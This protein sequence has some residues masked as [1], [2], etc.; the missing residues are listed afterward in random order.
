MEGDVGV[1]QGLAQ[2]WAE[3]LPD[4]QTDG[5]NFRSRGAG[6][7]CLP[8][9]TRPLVCLQEAALKPH[10]QARCSS[11]LCL[12]KDAGAPG[13]VFLKRDGEEPPYVG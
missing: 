2:S 12:F 6:L 13:R 9:K 4:P 5:S 8:R 1:G 3:W 10:V 7:N 11:G